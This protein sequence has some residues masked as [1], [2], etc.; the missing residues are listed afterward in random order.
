[1]ENMNFVTGFLSLLLIIVIYFI[2]T[3]IALGKKH[4]AG[5]F[6]L[7]AALGWTIVGYIAC[8]IWA[9]V[10]KSEDI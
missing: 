4:L 2:P 9:C 7:N 3:L 8:F 1:M 5:I 10:D 6:F